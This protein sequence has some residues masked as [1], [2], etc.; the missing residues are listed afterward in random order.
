MEMILESDLKGNHQVVDLLLLRLGIFFNDGMLGRFALLTSSG[1]G[2]RVPF[3]HLSL[4]ALLPHGGCGY[5]CNE[6]TSGCIGVCLGGISNTS[7][8]F[9]HG[10]PKSHPN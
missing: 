6:L 2:P 5:V 3:S 4:S 9:D 7:F 1:E 10:T 8:V